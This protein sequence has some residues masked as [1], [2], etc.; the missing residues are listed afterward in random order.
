MANTST[1][2]R[3]TGRAGLL[4]IVILMVGAVIPAAAAHD[5]RAAPTGFVTARVFYGPTGT[6]GV[7]FVEVWLNNGGLGEN[8]WA[9]TDANGLVTVEV[10]AG[11]GWISATGRAMGHPNGEMCANADFRQKLG[12]GNHLLW[13]SYDGHSEGG[14][15]DTFEVTSGNTTTITYRPTIVTDND[16]FPDWIDVC[17]GLMVTIKGTDGDD[18]IKGTSGID[19]INAGKGHDIVYGYEGNDVICGGGKSDTIVGG[20]GNDFI[21][22]GFGRDFLFGG[23][24]DDWLIGGGFADMMDGGDGIDTFIGQMG[25]DRAITTPGQGDYC[26]QQNTSPDPWVGTTKKCLSGMA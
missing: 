10:T 14:G 7:P 24:G 25:F 1:R 12:A 3:S 5:S 23:L 15:F 21:V 11:T 26:I 4:A 2:T 20:P 13:M 9:C 18:F 8:H 22:G 6:V 16:G 17:A 19:V